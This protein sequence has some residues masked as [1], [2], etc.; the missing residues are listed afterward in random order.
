MPVAHVTN[1]PGDIT[2][3]KFVFFCLTLTRCLQDGKTKSLVSTLGKVGAAADKKTLLVL[4]SAD[5]AVM[6]AGRNVAKLAINTADAIQVFDVLNADTIV[7]EK[8]ALAAVQAAYAPAA[9]PA[10]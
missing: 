8:S 5:E 10:Q 7:M 9:K 6:R 1:Q 4:A 3:I 2:D